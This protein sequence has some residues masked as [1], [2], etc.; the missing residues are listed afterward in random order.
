[1]FNDHLRNAIRGDLDGT[2][3]GFATGEGGDTGAIKRG[4]AGA[5]DDFTTEP[6]ETIN[7]ASAHDN[8]VLWDKITKTAPNASDEDRRAMQKLA[9]GIVLTSQGVPFIHGGCDFARTKQGNHNSY[10]AGDEIN[11]FGWSRK[12]EYADIFEFTRGLIELRRA[13]PAFRMTDDAQI[14]QALTFANTERPVA[15]TLDGRVAN[16]S[17][18]QIFVAYNDEPRPLEVTLPAGEWIVVVD[19]TR[20]GVAPLTTVRGRV[21]LPPYSML[22][23]HTSPR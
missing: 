2:T 17:W 12:S 8:L 9:L 11:D 6:T 10:N 7:Y 13:H 16:D 5:I 14:R 4:V 15:F 21:T 23:A 19:A 3:V 1:V 22:V 20:A 18:K